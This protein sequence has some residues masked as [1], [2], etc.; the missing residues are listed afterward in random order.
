MDAEDSVDYEVFAMMESD[1]HEEGNAPADMTN[2]KP[3]FIGNEYGK[4][5]VFSSIAHPEATPGMRWMIPRMVRWTL[6]K[7]YPAYSE[8]AVRPD[9]FNRE[10]LFT[11]E[12]LKR[13]SAAYYTLLYGMPEEK[14]A[15][16]DWLQEHLS[17]TPNAGCRD[18]ST[19]LLRRCAPVPPGTSPTRNGPGIFRT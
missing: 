3:F 12:M 16:L 7:D 14:I 1:V 8:N 19:M 9:L 4:G 11:K 17:G 2:G 18:W 6:R 13:E 10:I 5:R 15:T